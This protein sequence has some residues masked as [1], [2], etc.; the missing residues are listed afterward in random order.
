MWIINFLIC[1]ALYS[2]IIYEWKCKCFDKCMALILFGYFCCPVFRLGSLEVNGSYFITLILIFFCLSFSQRGK[3]GINVSRDG[4]L[5]YQIG[6]IVLMLTAGLLNGIYKVQII[7]SLIGILNIAI[8]TYGCIIFFRRINNP[9]LA[10]R[11]AVVRA[12]SLHMI[13][14]VIQLINT[15]A[16]YWITK[17]L[18][19]T[20]SRSIPIDTIMYEVGSFSRVYG[21]TY[22]PTILGGYVLFAFSFVLALMLM[23][24]KGK[25]S[26][27]LLST[28]LL[29]FM[30]YS[31]TAIIGMPVIGFIFMLRSFFNREMQNRKPFLQCIG[32]L[33]VGF[34]VIF[35]L[36][37]YF[38]RLGQ[39][40]YYFGL[41][42]NPLQVFQNRYGSS[43]DMGD[44][45]ATSGTAGTLAV[46]MK[47]PVIGVGMMAVFDEFL[48]DSQYL[49]LLHDGGI[50]LFVV[51][52]GFYL[53]VYVRQRNAKGLPQMM[54]LAALMLTAFAINIFTVTMYIPFIALCIGVKGRLKSEKDLYP[55]QRQLL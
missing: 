49:S 41:F 24:K 44:L 14:A 38:G 32:L 48:G 45:N 15:S 43:V 25:N 54:L 52:V 29:G 51:T 6:A 36:A 8:G 16:G 9:F 2:T 42:R 4:Y 1:I 7:I 3:S 50:V 18:Y 30:A 10:L 39:V 55:C 20:A 22:S 23:D 19:V 47:H 17:Q 28:V 11:R 12:N 35:L 37:V 21:A 40:Q 13:F 31:K 26:L 53:S 46:F 27:L 34:A 5:L 33:L